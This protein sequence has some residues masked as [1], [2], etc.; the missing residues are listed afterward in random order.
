MLEQK[1]EPA[2]GE[3]SMSSHEGVSRHTF[4]FFIWQY[5]ELHRWMV[6]LRTW[7]ASLRRSPIH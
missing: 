2:G 4:S 1:Q 7:T 6:Y 3:Q 5:R